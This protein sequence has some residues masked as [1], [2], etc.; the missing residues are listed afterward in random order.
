[1]RRI[2]FFRLLLPALLLPFLLVL[3]LEFRWKTAPHSDPGAG[4]VR[5]GPEAGGIDW[6]ELSGGQR[7]YAAKVKLVRQES[8]G[9]FQLEGIERLEVDR[10]DGQP[11][12]ISAD[13]AGVDGEPGQRLL[14][15][16][17][18]VEI[19]EEQDELQVSLPEL[20]VDQAAGEARSIGAVSLTTP[21]HSGTAG[22]V[23]YGLEGQP[24]RLSAVRL[25]S[26]DGATLSTQRATLLDGTRDFELSGDV[27][28]SRAREFMFADS[29]RVWRSAEGRVQRVLASERA[30]GA[31]V[32]PAGAL[33]RFGADRIETDWDEAGDP[34]HLLM[35][36]DAALARG[37]ESLIASRIEA[38]RGVENAGEWEVQ[39]EGSVYVKTVVDGQRA[40]LRAGSVEAL[41][42]TSG[43]LRRGRAS[44]GVHFTGSDVWAEASEA[45]FAPG[46]ET[47]I[48]LIAGPRRRARMARGRTRV[49]AERIVTDA[50]GVQ[51]DARDKVEAT[52]LPE[53]EPA[54]AE[55]GGLFQADQAVHFV[56]SRLV[57]Q[58]QGS[59]LS[60]SGSVR[61]W[62]GDRT[63]SADEVLMDHTNNDL[64]ADGHVSTRMPRDESVAALSQA[65]FIQIS[66]DHLDYSDRKRLA[67]YEGSTRVRQAEGWMEAGR[68]E[69]ELGEEGGIIQ[70]RAF[71]GIRFEYRASGE[72][73]VPRPVTGE[74]DRVVYMPADQTVILFGDDN[75][76]TVRRDSEVTM[77]REL[78]YRLDVGTVDVQS[79]DQDRVRIRTS[80]GSR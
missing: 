79:G 30:S 7:A 74:G 37:A 42:D 4:S 61:G 23:V 8:D 33:V 64:R 32:S 16:Q 5:A 66:A 53:K 41:V 65:D 71:D 49:S 34:E 40:I 44:G 69:I 24:T 39:A 47:E 6:Q 10:A 60:F 18:G 35:V 38:S 77:G 62:Q 73:G 55:S 67:V 2:H 19:R 78:H 50:R 26:Q 51:L 46:D 15:L 11:L 3:A 14:K 72:E 80:G 63:L 21:S 45:T 48:E 52:L 43:L 28:I 17:G 56:S 58:Q 70:V 29:M 68:V 31:L 76:A 12:I 9:R 54:Q 13:L 1:M 36:G 22:S 25:V 75:P 20:E 59:V 57:G 27:R